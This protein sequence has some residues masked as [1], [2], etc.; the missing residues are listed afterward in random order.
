MP[1]TQTEI[2]ATDV[3]D[4]E[5][6]GGF[7]IA[8]F[9]KSILVVIPRR[10][11]VEGILIGPVIGATAKDG[12]EAAVGGGFIV[13]CP[14]ASRALTVPELVTGEVIGLPHREGGRSLVV[15][16]IVQ[17]LTH[18]QGFGVIVTEGAVVAELVNDRPRIGKMS[19]IP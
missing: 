5:L 13:W 15:T 6:V 12:V 16:H 9:C 11:I 3:D 14:A 4:K 17:Q 10:I 1:I 7:W 18:S 19:D 8:T 2:G